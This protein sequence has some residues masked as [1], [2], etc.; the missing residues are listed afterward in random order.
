MAAKRYANVPVSR[1]GRFW[2]RRRKMRRMIGRSRSRSLPPYLPDAVISNIL[3]WLPSK[4]AIRCKAVCKAWHAMVSDRHFVSDHLERSKERPAVL[5]LPCAYSRREH[6]V[7]M[8]LWI[9]FYYNSGGGDMTELMY[10]E[11]IPKSIGQCTL[12]LHCDGLILTST[13][14]Q[15]VMVCNPATREFVTSPKGSHNLNKR[16]RVGLGFD[17]SSSKYKVA[18]FFYQ[19]E[20]GKTSQ[21]IC[22]FEVLTLGT[23]NEWRRT[24]DPPYPIMGVT[25]GHMRGAIYWAVDLPS[26]EH[27]NAFLRFDLADE[28]FGL[29]PYPPC[30]RTEPTYFVELEGELCCACFT[31]KHLVEAEDVVEIW[32]C[33][34][35]GA[36]MWALR[37]TIPIPK[38]SI[39]PYPAGGFTIPTVMFLGEHLLLMCDHKLQEFC[40]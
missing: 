11:H 32:T 4:S 29:T 1:L 13:L 31:G 10:R 16:P 7:L 38:D 33:D 9:D 22:R 24:V 18:R 23:D 8:S 19:V 28:K 2:P 14:D 34:G 6:N 17:P 5:L 25:P 3:S 12:P 30:E 27:P 40:V 20:D 35:T 37:C 36:P 15:E 26:A 39:V 21:P